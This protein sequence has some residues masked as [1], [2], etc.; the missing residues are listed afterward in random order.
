MGTNLF[1]LAGKVG[2]VTGAGRGIGKAIALGLAEAG[3]D[4]VVVSRTLSEVELVKSQI[5]KVGRKGLALEVDV[6]KRKDIDMMVH[7]C[8]ETFEKVD[9]LVNNAGISVRNEIMKV[10]MQDYDQVMN[11]NLKGALFCA[12]RAAK[13]MIKS[14]GGRI[15]NIASA[16]GE[17]AFHGTGVY[18][19]SKAA[20]IHLT[21]TMALEWVQYGINVNA[22]GPGY[23]NTPAVS[24]IRDTKKDQYEYIV[25]RIPMKRWG[26]P[27]EIAGAAV[28]L[29]SAASS[30]L[31]GQT[32]FVDGGLLIKQ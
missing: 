18:R 19:A 13:E 7:K 23:C 30:Y 25:G 1:A 3:A 8:I 22:I 26:D 15:I 29:A 10:S 14:K 9:I 11:T 31:T 17:I 27:E 16:G 28:F 6:S 12:Q 21:K 24:D 20:L 4:V 5:E 2:I 32:I